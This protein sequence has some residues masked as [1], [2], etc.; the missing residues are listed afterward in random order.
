MAKAAAGLFSCPWS[1]IWWGRKDGWSGYNRDSRPP[2]PAARSANDSFSMRILDLIS[3]KDLSRVA[4]LQML[5]RRVVEGFCSGRHRSPHKGF[6]VE[7]KEHR[8]YVRGD[9]LRSIDWKVFAKSD[10]LY[11]REFEEET[12]LRCTLLVDRSGSMRYSG[13]RSNGISKYDYAQQLAASL[14]YLMLGQQDAVGLVTFDD[15]VRNGS[16]SK[17]PFASA[18]RVDGADHGRFETRDRFGWSVSQDRTETWS[19]RIGHHHLRLDGGR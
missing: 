9:E 13:E 6:S 11:I 17:P 7:F 8:P 2:P 16:R 10:R 3:P 15:Q 19:S 1:Q 14:T 5:A 18:G 4:K 12:N